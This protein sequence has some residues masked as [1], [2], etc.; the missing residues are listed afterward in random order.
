[1]AV[2]NGDAA[3][4]LVPRP[5][6][7]RGGEEPRVQQGMPRGEERLR[8]LVVVGPPV[9]EQPEDQP[10]RARHRDGVLPAGEPGPIDG[11]GH[12]DNPTAARSTCGLTPAPS[13]ATDQPRVGPHESGCRYPG[14]TTPTADL[15]A[16]L[17]PVQREAVT[18]PGGP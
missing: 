17:N 16:N 7:R 11:D 8:L 5:Q 3:V 14:G 10:A 13:Q 4:A 1:E 6:P 2:P 18:H 9:H 15:L 12:G